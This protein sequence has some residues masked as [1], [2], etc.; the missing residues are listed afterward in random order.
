[1]VPIFIKEKLDI[2]I[3]DLEKDKKEIFNFNELRKTNEKIVDSRKN[4]IL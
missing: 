2:A 1:M 4:K 3:K